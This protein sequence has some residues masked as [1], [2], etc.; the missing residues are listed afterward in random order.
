MLNSANNAATML[1]TNLGSLVVKKRKNGYFSCFD[2]KNE[3][4]HKNIEVFVQLMNSFASELNMLNSHFDNPHGMYKN[5]SSAKDISI[6][7]S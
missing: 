2:I 3:D 5:K 7:L 6:L 1:A 4:K